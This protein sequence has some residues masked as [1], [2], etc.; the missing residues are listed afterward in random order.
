MIEKNM[1]ILNKTGIH[2]RPASNL[3]KL[4]NGFKSDVKIVRENKIAN[5]KSII[6]IMS[7]GLTKGSEITIRI[8]GEDEKLAMKTI[9]EF[10]VNLN[11]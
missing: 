3:V 6:N 10:I 9:E 2:A 7:L 8:D 4:V 1:T 11:E 5:A